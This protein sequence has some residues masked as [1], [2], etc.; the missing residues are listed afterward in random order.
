MKKASIHL[1]PGEYFASSDNVAIISTI[2][3]SCV[4]ACMYDPAGKIFGMNHFLLSSKRYARKLPYYETDAGR[5][6]IQAME[7]LINRML[8]LGAKRDNLKVK[9]FGGASILPRLSRSDNYLCVGEVN[10]RFIREF[11][12]LEGIPLV[13]EDLGGELGRVVH[14][15]GSDFSVY[16]RKIQ[17]TR[18]REISSQERKFWKKQITQHEVEKPD[19][20]IWE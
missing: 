19:I 10:V 4:S 11:L 16:V 2:L 7:L 3:G 1:H 17:S 8:K 5:Y 15:H 13:G 9:A 6:G 14:F 12:D 20:S 18:S